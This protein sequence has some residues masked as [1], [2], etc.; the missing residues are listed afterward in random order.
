MSKTKCKKVLPAPGVEPQTLRTIIPPFFFI[1]KC[2]VWSEN[3][4]NPFFIVKSLQ[5]KCKE[6]K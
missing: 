4:Y 1:L 6:K 5:K 2:P 3:V